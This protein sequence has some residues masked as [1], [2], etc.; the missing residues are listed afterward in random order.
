MSKEQRTPRC[1]TAGEIA[2][3]K[4]RAVHYFLTEQQINGL[5]TSDARQEAAMRGN[6]RA[7]EREASLEKDGE[8]RG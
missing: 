6:A 5:T 1:G 7:R 8:P 2:E 3:N 4:S